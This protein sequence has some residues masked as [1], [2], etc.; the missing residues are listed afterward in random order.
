MKDDEE[1]RAAAIA[2][3]GFNTPKVVA[4]GEAE[5]AEEILRLAEEN[6]IPIRKDKAL[7]T[8]LTQVDIGAEI[9]P[10]LYVAVAEALAFAYTL[11][12]DLNWLDDK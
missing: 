6:A 5:V 1:T 12:D 3:D 7:T 8:L 10:L 11:Q 4:R 2:Y 9:P